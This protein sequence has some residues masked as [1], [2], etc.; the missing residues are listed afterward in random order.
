MNK[1]TR[2]KLLQGAA[3]IAPFA[4]LGWHGTARAEQKPIRLGHP[5]DFTGPSAAFARAQSNG[6]KMAIDQVNAEGGLLGRKLELVDRDSQTKPNLGTEHARELV[7]SGN[8]DFL[9]GPASSAVALAVS[10]IAKQYKKIVMMSTPNTP[11]LLIELFHPY[12]FNVSPSGVM[13]AR[14]LADAL[15]PKYQK[16]GFIGAD[17]EAAHQG[18]KYFK[19]RLAVKNPK[20]TFTTEQWPK[21]GESDYSPYITALLS[22]QPD[23]IYSYLFGADMIG[24]FKQSAAYGL[25]QKAPVGGLTFLVDLMS[26]GQ[27]MPDGM[28]GLM[29]APFFAIS[30]EAMTKFATDYKKRFDTYPD[31]NAI[32][33]HEGAHALFEAI[34]KA[35]TT[36]SDAV[37]KALET[38]SVPALTGTL[39]F[40]ALDHQC[41][42]PLYVGVTTKSDKYPFKILRDVQVVKAED[43]WSTPKEIEAARGKS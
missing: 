13:E 34:R 17:F 43:I 42:S 20:A 22:S 32:L 7:T 31:D 19:D 15:A 10:N 23:A 24:F 1:I 9:F 2:R 38:I 5:S 14:A 25:P 33:A 26:L 3:A 39:K 4:S 11:R 16:I 21:L 28:Y 27:D 40:R 29:R 36:D 30:N 35:G 41:N 12:V 6:I 37:V 8:V 18:L